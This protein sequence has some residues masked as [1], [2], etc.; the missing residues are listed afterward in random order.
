MVLCL[1]VQRSGRPSRISSLSPNA[2][3]SHG[4]QVPELRARPPPPGGRWS[5]SQRAPTPPPT[6]P[7]GHPCAA[8]AWAFWLLAKRCRNA[9]SFPTRTEICSASNFEK[10]F[11]NLKTERKYISSTENRSSPRLGMRLSLPACGDVAGG[12]CCG[13]GLRAIA[14]CARPRRALRGLPEALR[15][16]P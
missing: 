13:P 4:T 5:C 2:W 7:R 8:E 15:Q 9:P 3:V 11:F 6:L 16:H 14:P 10:F 12:P 1:R